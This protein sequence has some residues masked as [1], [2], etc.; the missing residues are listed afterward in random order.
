MS[1]RGL[2][3]IV[4]LARADFRER[5][6][7]PAYLVVLLGAVAL[8]WLALP[9]RDAHW[10]IV[11]AGAYR[12]VY[13]SAYVGAVAAL[14]ASMWLMIG[15]FF[16]IRG[17][18]TR[19]EATGV[20]Q[21]LAATPI[22]G[23]AYVLGKFLSNVLVLGSMTGVLAA[24]AAALQLIRG[25]SRAIDP[26]G[27]LTPFLL[28]TVPVLAI[29]AALA[30]VFET[31]RPL[32]GGFGTV[33]WFFTASLG[34][35]AGQGGAAPLGGLGGQALAESMRA[36]L[37]AMGVRVTEFSVGFMYLDDPLRTF[38]WSGMQLT[39]GFIADRLVLTLLSVGVAV[40]P[41]LWFHRFDT[42]PPAR[43]RGATSSV[44]PTA[45]AGL[46]H[47][48]VTAVVRG[49]RFAGLVS[50]E[51]RV[52]ARHTSGWWWLVAAG[53]ALCGLAAPA[54]LPVV[55]VW[56]VL[57]WSRLGAFRHES[58]VAG[59]LGAYPGPARRAA[60]EWTAGVLFTAALGLGPM[61]R[62]VLAGSL[63]SLAIWVGCVVAIPSLAWSLGSVT[64]SQRP[65]QVLYLAL[66]YAVV[67][68]VI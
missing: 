28:L 6:R 12:G 41:A 42:R 13:T 3:A 53:L 54:L 67:N 25:E 30:V 18:V 66:W 8:A 36:D 29:T 7:R 33:V 56:P 5:S 52:L 34:A 22:T 32:R 59:L 50:G 38:T 11:N 23:W 15:G 58:S 62:W 9:A 39:T 21:V 1:A 26:I 46:G 19:D 57:V 68:M 31:I 35:L 43:K 65:F 10:V 20:G 55:W 14:A 27:L 44:E 48:P 64:R 37:T 61:L 16:A 2:R 49:S 51:A 60:A 45:G 40:V 4:A 63:L 47:R 24:S 17:S